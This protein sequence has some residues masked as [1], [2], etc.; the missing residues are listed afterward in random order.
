MNDT[1]AR[2]DPS[3]RAQADRLVRLAWAVAEHLVGQRHIAA[4]PP[5]E[6]TEHLARLGALTEL[7]DQLVEPLDP[8]A[9]P[10]PTAGKHRDPTAHSPDPTPRPRPHCRQAP[11][12]TAHSPT[13]RPTQPHCRQ[14]PRPTAHSP[15]RRPTHPHCR[16][17]PR[18]T[19]RAATRRPTQ[20]HC[21]QAPRP[22]AQEPATAVALAD[23]FLPD[24][25]A[26]PTRIWR[27][28]DGPRITLAPPAPRHGLAW[29]PAQ[30][31]TNAEAFDAFVACGADPEVALT[32][33]V[34]HRRC[35]WP[36]TSTASSWPPGRHP[37]TC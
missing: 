11:R 28:I 37:G 23:E 34:R 6:R 17:A 18:P 9:R 29:L 13:R 7:I 27:F 21:R 26:T 4:V 2:L 8:V 36:G 22:T 31:Q 33:G 24:P 12:P 30:P 25:F 10:G 16:Q 32:E 35:F 14:A 19:T 15:T 20:P 5:G 3:D 1:L